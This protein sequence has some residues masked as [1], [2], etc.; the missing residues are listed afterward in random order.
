[1][2][3][4]TDGIVQNNYLAPS[5]SYKANDQGDAKIEYDPRAADKI[6]GFYSISHAY[7]GS[8]PVLAISFPG[9]NLYP[10]WIVGSNWVHTFSPSL[11][12]SAR[13]G[14]TRTIWNQG[15]PQDPTGAFGTSGNAKVGITFPN[16]TYNGFTNQN[17]GTATLAASARR[18]TTAALSTTPTA[19]STT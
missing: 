9:I 2:P 12:N 5:R 17:L 3:Q 4:P 15:F 1:M 7:D 6:T 13:V 14:F 10:T 19:T 18:L 8:T 16:Q 11:V